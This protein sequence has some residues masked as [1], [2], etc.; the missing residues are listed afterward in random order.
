MS[1]YAYFWILL[2]NLSLKS[3]LSHIKNFFILLFNQLQNAPLYGS[4]IIHLT[5]PSLDI[6]NPILCFYNQCCPELPCVCVCVYNFIHDQIY[7]EV[8]GLGWSAHVFLHRF[9]AK[10]MFSVVMYGNAS[11]PLAS[12]TVLF[13]SVSR[14]AYF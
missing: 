13:L 9:L 12:P 8:K 7:L 3:F 4:T 10:F 2:F 6:K 5:S 1:N 14:V 11:F